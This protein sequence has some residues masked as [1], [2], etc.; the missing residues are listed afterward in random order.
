MAS[1]VY[2]IMA[3]G[4]RHLAGS[5]FREPL[6]AARNSWASYMYASIKICG[7]ANKQASRLPT[8]TA[9]SDRGNL[10]LRNPQRYRLA[11]MVLEVRRLRM[12]G[13]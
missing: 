8:Q 9:L 11:T 4:A 6:R 13:M 1:W 10:S 3:D 12:S 2:Y 7:W 5:W